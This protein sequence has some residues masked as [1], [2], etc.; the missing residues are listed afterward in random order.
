MGILVDRK[1]DV[2]GNWQ[3][4]KPSV[5]GHIK[6][7]ERE[8]MIPLYSAVVRP[9]LEFC[10]QVGGPQHTKDM[11]LLEWVQRQANKILRGLTYLSCE[12]KTKK[13]GLFILKKRRLP[14]Q[15]PFST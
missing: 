14:L 7:R 6:S 5:L 12:D 2:N 11:R 15:Q 3:P 10:I 1:Q 13:L 8:R 9:H 4:K